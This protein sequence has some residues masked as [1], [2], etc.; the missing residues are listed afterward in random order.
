MNLKSRVEKME[1]KVLPKV[2]P[3]LRWLRPPNPDGTK[4]VLPPCTNPKKVEMR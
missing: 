3:M 4:A 1:D 2:L